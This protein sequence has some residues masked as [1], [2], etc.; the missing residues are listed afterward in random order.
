MTV[1]RVQ[2][3][4]GHYSL[5]RFRPL[6]QRTSSHIAFFVQLLS[7]FAWVLLVY[8]LGFFVG[9]LIESVSEG[10]SL[11]KVFTDLFQYIQWEAFFGGISQLLVAVWFVMALNRLL[12][13]LTGRESVAVVTTV[14]AYFLPYI[15]G[16]LM[17]TFTLFN[18]YNPFLYLDIEKTFFDFRSQ[19]FGDING[20]TLFSGWQIIGYFLIWIVVLESLNALA[21]RLAS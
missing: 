12:F 6:S 1:L 18:R 5:L 16:V 19:A 2:F 3:V 14:L 21:T 4:Q 7:I 10:E 9:V 13:R 15:Q 17:G 20:L 11:L 8:G